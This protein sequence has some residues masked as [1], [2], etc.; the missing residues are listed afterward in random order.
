MRQKAK[1]RSDLAWPIGLLIGLLSLCGLFIYVLFML[2]VVIHSSLR[3]NPFYVLAVSVGIGEAGYLLV[4]V[5]YGVPVIILQRQLREFELT[6]FHS[7]NCTFAT[8]H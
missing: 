4:T 2:T 8:T 6:A 7:T 1:M 5:L 3:Q